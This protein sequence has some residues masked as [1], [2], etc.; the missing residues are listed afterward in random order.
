[1][2]P[3]ANFVRRLGN[4]IYKV[5]F[6]IYRPLY[7][8][9]KAYADRAE[10]QLLSTHLKAGDVTVDAGANIGVY[11]RFLSRCVGSQGTVHSFEPDVTNFERLHAALCDTSN[12]LLNQL[13]LSDQTGESVLYISDNLNVDHRAYQT[14]GEPRRRVAIHSVRL[15][16]YFKPGERV[17]FIK[18]DIQGFEL[19]A[20]RGADRVLADNPTI[21]LLLEFWPYGLKRA[22]VSGEDLIEFLR[23]KGFR[24][25]TVT[26][27]SL[28]PCPKPCGNPDDPADYFNLF[29][30][31]STPA[32]ANVS[33]V[34]VFPRSS[35]T[36]KGHVGVAL[37]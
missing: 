34:D 24:C 37:I 7:S 29:A 36:R 23:D 10:R 14:E 12:V 25:F 31:P 2:I 6:P 22:G 15:D 17:D 3:A 26:N 28:S 8:V 1:M 33:T 9:F 19:H 35:P 5:G 32:N 13:A 4:E 27:G 21:R 30:Q 16:D 18:M 11:T 20:L